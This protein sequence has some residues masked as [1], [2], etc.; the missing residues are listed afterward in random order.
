VLVLEEDRDDAV[1]RGAQ[2]RLL[3]ANE[4]AGTIRSDL[5]PDDVL[6]SLGFL[7][8][9]DP[10]SDWQSRSSRLLDLL[11]DGLQAGADGPRLP[12]PNRPTM[13]TDAAHTLGIGRPSTW[14]QRTVDISTP[15]LRR[16]PHGAAPS[17]PAAVGAV[18]V[19]RCPGLRPRGFGLDKQL[20]ARPLTASRPTDYF[21]Y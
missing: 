16:D 2:E 6:L 19:T 7:W 8:R 18:A 4:Q 15:Q 13:S 12:G 5:D 10:N 14:P 17:N 21:P 11:M 1:L 9:I 3:D 20:S